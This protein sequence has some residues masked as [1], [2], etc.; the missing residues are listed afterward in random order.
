MPK[1]RDR[2]QRDYELPSDM[3][4]LARLRGQHIDNYAKADAQDSANALVRET[5]L[6]V[7]K[8]MMVGVVVVLIAV[9]GVFV[10]EIRDL[11]YM[12]DEIKKLSSDGMKSTEIMGVLEQ[13]DRELLRRHSKLS[14]L[15]DE[16]SDR[17]KTLTR[18]N[19]VLSEKHV[20]LT[21]S[22]EE[23]L[24]KHEALVRDNERLSERHDALTGANDDLS[25]K[26]EAL[27]RA[28]GKL[29]TKYDALTKASDEMFKR[30]EA[31]VRANEELFERM[32][33]VEARER[34]SVRG[35]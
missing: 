10:Y 26:H 28:N 13:A 35:E 12:R 1:W 8:Y 19:R 24:E 30:H 34:M 11:V 21:R 33:S 5:M 29:Q 31:L 22:I 27:V 2:Q 9:Q 25:E 17:H 23:L 14:A 16:L 32:R 20:T 6:P 15:V 3:E 7:R 4:E 18:E